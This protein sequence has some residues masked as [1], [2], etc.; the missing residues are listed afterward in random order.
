MKRLL[1][2]TAAVASVVSVLA[3]PAVAAGTAPAAT[4]A[5]IPGTYQPLTAV[6]VLDTRSGNVPL[7]AHASR[8]VQIDGRGAVPASGVSAAAIT[9]SVLTPTAT[10]SVGVFPAGT[11]TTAAG[12]V[13]F[14]AKATQQSALTTRLSASGAVVVRNNTS[15]ALTVLIDVNGYY[16]AGTPTV[17]GAFGVVPVTRLLDTRTST[18]IPARGLRK[19]TVAG[20]GGVPSSG[21]GAAQINVGVLNAPVTGSISV[22]GGGGN[23][24]FGTVN[25]RPQL[26]VQ[27]MFAQSLYGGSFT[28]ANNT[29][30]PLTV[31]VDLAGYYLAGTP[32]ATGAFESQSPLFRA[33]DTRTTPLPSRG[34]TPVQLLN[35]TGRNGDPLPVSGISGVTVNVTIVH[36]AGS[37]SVTVYPDGVGKPATTTISF[38]ADRTTQSTLNAVVGTNGGL[39]VV[40][41]SG[42]GLQVVADVS[43]YW[44]GRPDPLQL[45]AATQLVDGGGSITTDVSCAG[46]SLCAAVEQ[47]G[48]ATIFD[49]TQWTRARQIDVADT[50]MAVSCTTG[51]CMTVG[52]DAVAYHA[53]T[54][55][56]PV[57]VDASAPL[58]GVSCTSS[59]FCL[60]VDLMGRYVTFDGTSWT[61][62]AS[63]AGVT[64]LSA[65]SC[66]SATFC[67]AVGDGGVA[68]RYDGTGWSAPSDVDGGRWLSDVS[69]VT[70]SFCGAAGA[71]GSFV[72]YSAAG[73]SAPTVLGGGSA[74]LSCVTATFCAAV[75][76]AF[77][78]SEG[79]VYNGTSW[80]FSA[81][82]PP[83]TDQISCTSSTNCLAVVYEEDGVGSQRFNGTHWSDAGPIPAR[84]STLSGITCA[85]R[86]FCEATDD[87]GAVATWNGTSWGPMTQVDAQGSITGISCLVDGSCI[88]VD[89][90]AH[91][92]TLADGTWSAPVTIDGTRTLT[93]VSCPAPGDCIA[94]DVSGYAVRM[95]AGVWA[96][97]VHIEGT[98]PL[99]T[100]AC[101]SATFCIAADNG[102]GRL[103][104]DGAHWSGRVRTGLTRVDATSCA[105]VDFCVLS[106][107]PGTVTYDGQTWTSALSPAEAS[108]MSCG[109]AGQCQAGLADT[110]A[111]F[112]GATWTAPVPGAGYTTGISCPDA[113]FC[114]TYYA[115]GYATPAATAAQ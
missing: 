9:L 100:L 68:V 57:S 75:A 85:S 96:A 92:L 48:Y 61:N 98:A 56:A 90:E 62:P 41:N 82:L 67:E 65:V 30:K 42:V 59:S 79:I 12:T 99:T 109:A 39:T 5:S 110:A 29:A 80:K 2:L 45:G 104:F 35:L 49:G 84:G 28:I 105:T 66:V 21:V 69:C 115:G 47:P 18:A 113:G 76:G 32:T 26:T 50:L 94:I 108:A 52:H 95:T 53:G 16:L 58:E 25:F 111:G 3:V 15:V 13:S 36:P 64:R 102:G 86:Q 43:G 107:S 54:W 55:A 4:T 11:V 87:N 8:A 97:P 112:D 60:A 44:S 70:T 17:A 46:A 38:V 83:L 40:N 23:P 37:G 71:G 6:R 77:E 20:H 103:T 7:A 34:T 89:S 74:R 24:D 93:A 33:L 73:W 31:I 19:I 1:A 88:A 72:H 81:Q 51:F 101:P 27:S 14:T 10:G 63:V 91:A 22:Y 114:M 78:S 106:G